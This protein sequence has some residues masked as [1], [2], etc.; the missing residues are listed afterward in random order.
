[1][2]LT[3]KQIESLGYVNFPKVGSFYRLGVEE[4]TGE[5]RLELMP[6]SADGGGYLC[7]SQPLELDGGG[8]TTP[9]QLGHNLYVMEQIALQKE[10]TPFMHKIAALRDK[11]Y[12]GF[13]NETDKHQFARGYV[14]DYTDE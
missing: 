1:M 6:Q 10:L 4:I 9:N 5:L 13:D 11:L 12:T 2:N 7:E 8:Y 14:G 3:Q